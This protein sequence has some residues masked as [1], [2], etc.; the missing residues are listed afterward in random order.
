MIYWNVPFDGQEPYAAN[1]SKLYKPNTKETKPMPKTKS[2]S[3]SF[4][5][6]LAAVFVVLAP[7][8]NAGEISWEWR[9]TNQ[10]TPNTSG[11]N[12]L[13]SWAD[14][15]TDRGLKID[16]ENT[17]VYLILGNTNP[18]YP[19]AML[20]GPPFNQTFCPVLNGYI[21]DEFMDRL[22]TGA[23][24]PNDPAIIAKY[25]IG[26]LKVNGLT[27]VREN[28]V[29]G[30]GYSVLEY[31]AAVPLIS[32]TILLITN[33]E[34]D[35]GAPRCMYEYYYSTATGYVRPDG[36]VGDL[37]VTTVFGTGNNNNP[38][39]LTASVI[40]EPATGLLA[41]AGLGLLLRRR[42]GL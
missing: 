10:P 8:A 16:K 28:G 2:Q 5:A 17:Y 7:A 33:V 25:M 27:D 42:R 34:G 22:A 3:A 30:V 32:L 39:K 38:L 21:G 1:T 35:L 41:L 23:F 15:F 11:T 37:S 24:D 4:L 29:L 20:E 40:P 19:Y 6:A 9:D 14:Y 13:T 36:E 31:P 18:N 12:P 26:D